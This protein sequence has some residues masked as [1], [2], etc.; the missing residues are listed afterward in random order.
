PVAGIAA[1]VAVFA[2]MII[3]LAVLALVVVKALADSPWGL[4]TIAATIPIAL[5]MGL[6]MRVFRPG[7]VGEASAIG[8]ILLLLSIV[9]GRTVAGDPTLGPLFTLTGPQ[10]AWALIIYGAIAAS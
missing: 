4:F 9:Y 5:L 1:M 10:L 6:Y 2:I 7:K 8:V 3:L